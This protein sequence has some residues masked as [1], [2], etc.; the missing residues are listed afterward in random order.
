MTQFDRTEDA[1]GNS[2]VVRVRR[3]HQAQFISRRMAGV[4]LKEGA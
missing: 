2:A 1:G 4:F 3:F